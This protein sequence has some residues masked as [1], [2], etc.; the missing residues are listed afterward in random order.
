MM[1]IHFIYIYIASCK[2]P[3][4]GDCQLNEIPHLYRFLVQYTEATITMPNLNFLP[5]LVVAF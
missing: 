4:P 1:F 5:V 2:F 3:P